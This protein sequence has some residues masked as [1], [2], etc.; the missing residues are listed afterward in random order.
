MG[1]SGD[2]ARARPKRLVRYMRNRYSNS[3]L[4]RSKRR[5]NHLGYQSAAVGITLLMAATVVS[6]GCSLLDRY[7]KPGPRDTTASYHDNYGLSIEYPEVA[8]CATPVTNAA[9]A[10]TAPNS[11]E[12]PS[13]LPTL[14]LT[15]PEAIEMALRQSPVI[16]SQG[17]LVGA[18]NVFSTNNLSTIYDPSITASSVQGTEAAL[19]AFDAQYQQSLLFGNLDQPANPPFGF[20][21]AFTPRALQGNTAEYAHALTKRT[22]TGAS[23]ALR[24]VVNYN[25]NNRPFRGFPTEFVGWVEAEWRQPLMKGA[26]V[27]YNRIAG[28]RGI[29]GQYNGVLIARIN[30]DVALADFERSV[31]Q[32]AR[33][34][35]TAYW[36]LALAYRVLEATVKG[37][38]SALRTFQYQQVRLEVGA[39]RQDE[40]AQAQSQYYQFQ[41]QVENQLAGQQGLYAAEQSLRYLLGLPATD[42][43][44]IRPTTEPTDIKVA[45]DWESA[46]VQALDRRVELRRQRF[47]VKR[48]EME[49]YAAR[50][51]KRPQLD[52]ISQYR[53]RGLGDHLIGDSDV[54]P[55]DGLYASIL[56]G[57]YQ[58]WNA[59]VELAFPV[60]LRS[61]SVAVSNAKLSLQRERA[62]LAESE[63]RIS[64]DLSAQARQ[65]E[66]TFQL[67]ETNFNRFQSDIRQ[68]EV[69]ERR[70]R[71]GSDNINF[72]LQAQSQLVN[73]EIAFYQA[74]TNYNLAILDFHLQKGSLLAYNQIQLAEGPWAAGAQSDAYQVGRFLTPRD[75]N[76]CS[77]PPVA[78]G[79]FN[80][81]AVQPSVSEVDQ[82]TVELE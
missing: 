30:E 54:N 38:E 16:R 9:Q 39:G 4:S 44:I 46:L 33:E 79:P 75:S 62:L 3:S 48:R 57:N 67:V 17:M 29:D 40:E 77:P 61:A 19:S 12:D 37:R 82:E 25:A 71:D 32:L 18:A 45:F 21:A 56:D 10:A 70:Y 60:G 69:L 73:S 14:D 20:G 58:E 36:N 24:H 43:K 5:K 74:M 41:A 15:L 11:L 2:P 49:L 1:Q 8:Q 78:K 80:P 51:N 59:G 52:F 63:L 66:L 50:L 34:V 27:Q 47:N 23:F 81:S 26:G 28:T 7:V 72:L 35:E 53:W 55:L 76:L 64:H 22:A 31:I 42:G 65:I 68:V 13:Q 6:S